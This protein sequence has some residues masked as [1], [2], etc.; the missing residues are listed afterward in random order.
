VPTFD[1]RDPAIA[2]MIDEALAQPPVPPR[3]PDLFS[4]NALF[5][6][7]GIY[8]GGTPMEP[9]AG[10]APD[11]AT[12]RAQLV[13]VLEDRAHLGV[14]IA[15]ALARYDE[16]EKLRAAAPAPVVRAAVCSA[17]V[18]PAALTSFPAHTKVAR[19]GVGALASP[20]RVIGPDPDPDPGGDGDDVTHRV[21]NE[22]YR[23]E[24]PALITPSLVHD[25][26]WTPDRTDHTAETLLHA[27]LA[28]VHVKAVAASP[29]LAHL[30]TELARRQNSLAIT[31][32]NSRHPG[33]PRIALI[34]PDGPGTIPGGAPGMQSPDF[35]S[36]PFG[37]EDP[38]H[39]VTALS[40]LYGQGDPDGDDDLR[41]DLQLVPVLARIIDED[42]R[43]LTPLDQL[44][45]S[46]ALGLVD[47]EP[48][49]ASGNDLAEPLAAAIAV[50]T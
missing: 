27:M 5:G 7:P 40:D 26:M 44:R 13:A 1:D 31:L 45:A 33:S 49:V 23:A 9:A 29:W 47:P 37:P 22:R 36:I 41:W 32:L 2:A 14:D 20:G 30:G 6:Q 10:E 12:A 43:W 18:G 25:L 3:E 34:A 8:P 42:P 21:L 46:V 15:V 11:E 19:I 28:I 16:D 39:P 35:W 17:G 48:I 24:H 50:W 4:S 38:E